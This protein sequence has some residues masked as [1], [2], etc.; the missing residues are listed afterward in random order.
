MAPRL[1]GDFMLSHATDLGASK[2]ALVAEPSV[3]RWNNLVFETWNW[4]AGVSTD[5]GSTFSYINPKRKFPSKWGGFCCDQVVYYAPSRGIFVWVMMYNEDS[6]GNNGIRL[7]VTDAAGL[8]TGAFWYW[9][10]TPKQLHLKSGINFDQPDIAGS[11]NFLYMEVEEFNANKGDRYN[12]RSDVL[13][14]S[15]DDLANKFLPGYDFYSTP[16]FGPGMTSGAHAT[17]YFAAH[18]D[19]DTLRV[20]SWPESAVPSG[21]TSV[22]VDHSA[23][24]LNRPYRCPTVFDPKANWC[25]RADDRLT[26]GWV[27]SGVVGFHWNAS[28][29]S[30]GLGV[31]PY[32]YDHVVRL[33]ESTKALLSEPIVWSADVAWI[34]GAVSPN[35]RG[36]LGGSIL[37]GGG[38]YYESCAVLLWDWNS[39]GFWQT[40]YGV[41]S[42]SV[43]NLP[44]GGDYLSS[45]PNAGNSNTWSATCYTLQ[46]GGDNKNVHPWYLSFGRE[47]DAPA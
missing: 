5:G 11:D 46:G 16:L 1:P 20:F 3:A 24:P 36:D 19:N 33:N 18:V 28:Q 37:Y 8:A 31:F 41:W 27:A 4:N 26:N 6:N 2:A 32:P 15:L 35:A 42:D 40:P 29:G 14:F 7:A 17:M 21:V 38:L 43:P 25:G 9:D 13:R 23:Y 10:I 45:Y 34:Y 39:G 47:G 44:L 30:G 22:D 12:K